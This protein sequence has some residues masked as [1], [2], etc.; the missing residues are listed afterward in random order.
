MDSDEDKRPHA[1]DL[2]SAS[3]AEFAIVAESV[4]AAE[5]R[6]NQA[7]KPSYAYQ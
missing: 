4:N 1:E 3:A 5:K 6:K 7:V 2:W